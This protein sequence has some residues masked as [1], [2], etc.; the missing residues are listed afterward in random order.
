MKVIK[1]IFALIGL[2]MLFGAYSLY[3]GT[4]SFLET[5]VSTQGT[6][7][8]LRRSR[9]SDGDDTYAPVVQ[10]NTNGGESIEFTSSTSSNPPSYSRGEPVEV[11]YQEDSPYDAKI[12]GFFSLWGAALIVGI[13]GAIFFLIGFSIIFFGM[14]KTKMVEDLKKNGTR[15]NAEFQSVQLNTTLKVNGRNPYQILAQWQNPTTTEIH[16]FNSDNLW[17]DPT[18]YIKSDVIEVLVD[19][20]NPKKYHVDTSFLPKIAK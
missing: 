14:K 12:K 16:I 8:D 13:F 5:A 18:D 17:F 10:F 7:I 2:A 15:V 6:V 3:S 4:Q 9:S 1:Y 20:Q 19:M 11:L